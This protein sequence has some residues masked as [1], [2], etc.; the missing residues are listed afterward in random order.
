MRA[1]ATGSEP[2]IE[3]SH[4][5]KARSAPLARQARRISSHS[6]GPM[7]TTTTCTSVDAASLISTACSSAKVSHSFR[8]WFR[9]SSSTSRP[10][11]RIRKSSSSAATRL[12]GTR[13]FM[14]G[15][16]GLRLLDLRRHALFDE[17]Q[18]FQ[19]LD[20]PLVAGRLDRILEHGQILRAGH[21]ENFQALDLGRLAD[22]DLRRLVLADRVRHPDSPA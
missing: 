2:A 11:A 18:Q 1:I 16:H 12:T 9:Y 8:S 10:S 13:I 21:H 3:S 19:Y 5:R 7:V 22:P 6:A 4:T 20:A 15:R 17:L 14:L